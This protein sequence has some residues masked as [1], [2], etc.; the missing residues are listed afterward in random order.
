MSSAPH[1]GEGAAPCLPE[2]LVD[3]RLEVADAAKMN[4]RFEAPGVR[5]AAC[6]KRQVK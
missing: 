2:H 6:R 3:E 5:E 1:E 4:R